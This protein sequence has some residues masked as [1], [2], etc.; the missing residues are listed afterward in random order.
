ML[1]CSQWMRSSGASLH[2]DGWSIVNLA[3]VSSW[4]ARCQAW[5]VFDTLRANRRLWLCQ[6]IILLL[7]ARGI[8][9][10]AIL[11]NSTA[12][13]FLPQSETGLSS[14]KTAACFTAQRC[15]MTL[16]LKEDFLMNLIRNGRDKGA[17]S[18]LRQDS[19]MDD[20]FQWMMRVFWWSWT[21]QIGVMGTFIYVH[22]AIDKTSRFGNP[23]Q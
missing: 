6:V 13:A 21:N 7:S 10:N 3:W 17:S 15:L 16:W 20:F 22:T 4:N 9:L 2:S 11:N 8:Y 14:G 5:C 1:L 19:H 23:L 18:W 12:S